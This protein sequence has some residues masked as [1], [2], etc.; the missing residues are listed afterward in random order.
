MF[1][2]ALDPEYSPAPLPE[3]VTDAAD[4]AFAELDADEANHINDAVDIADF[5]Y[6]PKGEL[7]KNEGARI[8]RRLRRHPPSGRRGGRSGR[9]AVT[10]R[11]P[12]CRS[13]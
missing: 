2:Q 3:R 13:E 4:K 9:A 10:P 5:L 7:V 8:R 1:L 6:A 12:R 11:R